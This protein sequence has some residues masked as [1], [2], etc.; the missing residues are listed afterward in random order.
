MQTGRLQ[1]RD[2][3]SPICLQIVDCWKVFTE[4]EIM[5]RGWGKKVNLRNAFGQNPDLCNMKIAEMG[6]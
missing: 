1:P 4:S 6:A 2:S 5:R 3:I